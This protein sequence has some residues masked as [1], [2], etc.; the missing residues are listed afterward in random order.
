MK[1]HKMIVKHPELDGFNIIQ[2]YF[3]RFARVV[4]VIFLDLSLLKQKVFFFK[5]KQRQKQVMDSVLFLA[6]FPFPPTCKFL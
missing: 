1:R 2:G 3:R 4:L 6:F 5:K